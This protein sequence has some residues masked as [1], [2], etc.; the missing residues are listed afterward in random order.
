[1]KSLALDVSQSECSKER[2]G[3]TAFLLRTGVLYNVW[4]AAYIVNSLRCLAK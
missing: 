3:K 1:M 2:V 4:K